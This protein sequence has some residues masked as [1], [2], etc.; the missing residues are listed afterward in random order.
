MSTITDQTTD[1]DLPQVWATFIA[2]I[3]KKTEWNLDEKNPES[4]D[5]VISYINPAKEEPAESH[6]KAKKVWRSTLVSVDRLGVFV[7][8]F[9]G[10]AVQVASVKYKEVFANITTLMERI[11]V[12]LK[13]LSMYMDN[14]NAEVK[15]DK[16]L[17]KTVY[18]VLEC[19]VDILKTTHSLTTEQK[20][21]IKLKAKSFAFG[22]DEG[23]KASL[24]V[25]ETL[26]SNFTGAQ[27]S[28]IVQDLSEA[29]R[30]VRGIDRKLDVL[31]DAAERQTTIMTQQ[32][33]TLT[34]QTTTLNGQT[35]M[36]TQQT[37]TL[38]H[39][40]TT[41][42]QLAA[43]DDKQAARDKRP[44][45]RQAELWA[46]HV[47][48]IDQWLLERPSLSKWANPKSTAV[49]VFTLR[50]PS[51]FGK[52]Y[53]SS[54]VTH[55]IQQ[56]H[57]G[58]GRVV[59]AYYYF[60]K[61]AGEKTTRQMNR[62][63]KTVIWQLPQ[64]CRQFAKEAAKVCESGVDLNNTSN[65]WKRLITDS[66]AKGVDATLFVVLDG[67]DELDSEPG[68]PLLS[69]INQIRPGTTSSVERTTSL[70]VRL[71]ITGAPEVLDPLR[72]S[73]EPSL[74]EINLEPAAE[75]EAYV[76]EA[77]LVLYIEDRINRTERLQ[78]LD[79]ALKER[80][81]KELAKGA[82]GAYSR[83]SYLLDDLVNLQNTSQ[84]DDIL[85]RAN[86]SLT[87]MVA[88][89]IDALNKTLTR[90]EVVEAN[91]LLHWITASFGALSV[92]EY[93]AML[94]L[95]SDGQPLGLEE[96]IRKKYTELFSLD[97]NKLITLR[98]GVEEFLKQENDTLLEQ[99]RT[100]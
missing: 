88:D 98:D 89:M 42:S 62:A 32:T 47:E 99:G 59:V 57:R 90:N 68:K 95:G 21:R 29:A 72:N 41:L 84:I 2:R 24:T 19:L 54:V 38:D 85:K 22:E 66:S 64:A 25:M 96:R 10:F 65:A 71:F 63:I 26:V 36:L 60:Q 77:D 67:L 45:D 46:T 81:K 49:E 23:I 14:S 33:T 39:H 74:P 93:E 30:N 43:A 12:F 13:N 80:I 73:I 6:E 35:A 83:L 31:S 8:R 3:N 44:W 82:R 28:M 34:Q 79:D 7:Q 17:R 37:T 75:R 48:G 51:G 100:S 69:I 53:L 61:E 1:E 15:L 16:R 11:S 9:G 94:A 18:R 87:E 76:N 5:Q 40:T 50:A 97:E 4:V 58:D 55:H 91:V 86:Q 78:Q 56:Q 20:A 70:G 52:I 92:S 27:I